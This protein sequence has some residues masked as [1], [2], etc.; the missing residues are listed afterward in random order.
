[1]NTFYKSFL[2]TAFTALLT[3]SAIE[4][5]ANAADQGNSYSSSLLGYAPQEKFDDGRFGQFNFDS[6]Q[7]EFDE[8]HELND[9]WLG[10]SAY[11]NDGNYIGYIDDAILDSDGNV[12]EI[13]VSPPQ[14]GTA[15]QLQIQYATLEE[16]R[17]TLKLTGTQFASI[18][19]NGEVVLSTN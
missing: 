13:V 16:D 7:P 2:T 8:E 10:L 6:I 3:I 19:T 15:V 11:S 5:P 17:V 9:A 4:T 12:V 14:G 1:M 18:L